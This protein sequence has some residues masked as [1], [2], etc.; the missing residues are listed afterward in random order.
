MLYLLDIFKL[1]EIINLAMNRSNYC[2]VHNL[3]ETLN[4]ILQILLGH[5]FIYFLALSLNHPYLQIFTTSP[6][7]VRFPNMFKRWDQGL[8]WFLFAKRYVL[9]YGDIAGI[10]GI[11]LWLSTFQGH[12]QVCNCPG[13]CNTSNGMFCWS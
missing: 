8:F 9:N 12:V 10:V 6:E 3:L 2:S 5:L 1:L 13:C 7:S 11:R 4:L